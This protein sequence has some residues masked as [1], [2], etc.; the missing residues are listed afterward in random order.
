MTLKTLDLK[1][2]KFFRVYQDSDVIA[3][4]PEFNKGRETI[5]DASQDDDVESDSEVVEAGIETSF[6]DLLVVRELF[7]NK[8]EQVQ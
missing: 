3:D 4:L 1:N 2:D 8:P 7:K 6:K 5:V